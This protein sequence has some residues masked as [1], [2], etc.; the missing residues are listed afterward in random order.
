VRS[1]KDRHGTLNGLCI[2]YL[3]KLPVVICSER[4][5]KGEVT[6]GMRTQ[7]VY[8]AATIQSEATQLKS[9]SFSLP[10]GG[11]LLVIWND[12][13][14]VDF[15]PGLPSKIVIAGCAGSTAC[16]IDVLHG[17]GQELIASSENG[18]LVIRNLLLWDYPIIIRLSE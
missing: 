4:S 16:G 13:A 15:D 3:Q 5:L 6:I 2:F 14:A 8:M 18:D 9:F 1:I 17:F 11:E 12:V 10:D 7:V